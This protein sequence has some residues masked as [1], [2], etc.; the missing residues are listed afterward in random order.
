M[1]NVTS[2][3]RQLVDEAMAKA[4][5]E[6]NF[7]RDMVGRAIITAV[8]DSYK[9]YRKPKDIAEELQYTIDNLDEDEFV[10]TRGC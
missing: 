8:I 9:A 6:P 3:A 10:I 4:D 7:D 2:Y 5:Q 1:T